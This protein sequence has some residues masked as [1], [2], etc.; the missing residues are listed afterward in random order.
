[1]ELENVFCVSGRREDEK[2]VS[3][4]RPAVVFGTRCPAGLLLPAPR[5]NAAYL[6]VQVR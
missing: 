6:C 5:L 1:M 4:L 3:G 2:S